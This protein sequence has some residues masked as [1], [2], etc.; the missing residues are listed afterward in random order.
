M[1]LNTNLTLKVDK[2]DV[3]WKMYNSVAQ[4]G[5]DSSCNMDQILTALSSKGSAILMAPIFK[6]DYPNLI[7]GGTGTRH[8]L[9]VEH[10]FSGYVAITDYDISNG[11]CYF[12]SH[13]GDVYKVWTSTKPL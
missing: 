9:K 6:T 10:A 8:I 2:I 5:L 13:D 1:F 3:N 11:V 4:L 12:T 7:F